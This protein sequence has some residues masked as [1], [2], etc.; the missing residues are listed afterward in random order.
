MTRDANNSP[1]LST[2][3]E[4]QLEDDISMDFSSEYFQSS[5][6]VTNDDSF[7]PEAISQPSAKPKV[8]KVEL[9]YLFYSN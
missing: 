2:S 1:P 4:P 6:P 8:K 9:I 7:I 5:D 3:L